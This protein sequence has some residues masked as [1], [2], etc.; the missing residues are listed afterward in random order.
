MVTAKAGG[1]GNWEWMFNGYRVQFMQNENV[2]ELCCTIMCIQLT[3]LYCKLKICQQGRVHVIGFYYVCHDIW[4]YYVYFLASLCREIA[5]SSIFS[6]VFALLEDV[7]KI[8]WEGAHITLYAFWPLNWGAIYRD[9]N[10]KKISSISIFCFCK[11]VSLSFSPSNMLSKW[12][13]Y[14]TEIIKLVMFL[15]L[16]GGGEGDKGFIC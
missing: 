2:L 16:G 15:F 9:K 13:S 1:K 7:L 12:G 4:F 5:T 10:K 8:N 11:T 14:F 6:I 3:T